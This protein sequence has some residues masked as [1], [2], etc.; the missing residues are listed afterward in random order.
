VRVCEETPPAQG[1]KREWLLVCL[2]LVTNASEAW[3][4]GAWYACRWR[5]EEF[6]KAKK[7]GC[8]IESMQFHTEAALQPM[9]ALSSVAAV[10]L[11]NLRQ[12]ARQPDAQERKATEGGTPNDEEVLRGLR[13][14][15]PREE[16]SVYELYRAVARLG[17]HM[18]R[19]ADGFPGWLTRWRGGHKLEQRVA[20]VKRDRRRQSQNRVQR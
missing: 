2:D 5:V 9:I 3:E 17:G 20:G 7:T 15:Q 6:H 12:A 11:R 13:Y 18:N 10:R 19:K 4:K 8:R 14:K 16:R 1:V